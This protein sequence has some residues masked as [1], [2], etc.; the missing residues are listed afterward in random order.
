MTKA[1]V[2]IDGESGTTGL[3]I[4]ERPAPRGDEPAD[5]VALRNVLGVVPV[6]EFAGVNVAV[7]EARREQS[8][9][10]GCPLVM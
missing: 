8:F 9:G 5:A 3:G 4:R 10:H 6:V 2:F 7:V 1:K